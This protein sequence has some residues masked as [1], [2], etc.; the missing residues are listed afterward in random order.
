MGPVLVRCPFCQLQQRA[1][2]AGSFRCAACGNV[3]S[4]PPERRPPPDE[5]P[6]RPALLLQADSEPSPPE[7]RNEHLRE[8]RD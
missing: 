7:R 6:R 3:I 8:F 2:S 4:P 1:P 5:R